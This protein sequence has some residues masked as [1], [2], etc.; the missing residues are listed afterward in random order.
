MLYNNVRKSFDTALKKC[1]IIH[2]CFHDL[3]HTFASQ[4]VMSEVDL[5]TAQELMGHKSIEMTMR[6]ALLSS[7]HKKR[8]VEILDRQMDIFWTPEAQNTNTEDNWSLRNLL[9]G[10]AL[11]S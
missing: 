2:F 6:Y 9:L 5:K 7:S 8:A 11:I 10:K 4:L 3:R 1:G